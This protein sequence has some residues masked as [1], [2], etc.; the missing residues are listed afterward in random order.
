MKVEV[1]LTSANV[2][3]EDVKDRTV[4]V[5]DV[6][7]ACSTIATAL[8]NGAR[9]IVPVADMAQAS[10]IAS[11][12]DQ[13]SYLLG[14]ER[15]GDRIEGYHLGNSPLE[16]TPEVVKGRTI[17]LNTTNG[18]VAIAQARAARH[19]LIGSFLNVGRVVDFAREA[20]LDVTIICAGWRNRVSLEDTLCAG[21]MV[22]RLWDGVEPG[23]VSDTAHIAFTQYRNDKD[24]LDEAWQS[25]KAK[26]VLASFT[27]LHVNIGCRVANPHAKQRIEPSQNVRRSYSW[28]FHEMSQGV[29]AVPM[30]IP[31][32]GYFAGLVILLIAFDIL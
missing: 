25:I 19:L 12:L 6:L 29:I 32:I 21:Q 26:L 7:R 14:G 13:A 5:I 28:R 3:E 20:D 10:K 23:L 8:V 11:N 9:S 1:F 2:S 17:I 31:Q 16:Y 15:D 18:T 22:Y 30:W 24:R 27:S 4:I